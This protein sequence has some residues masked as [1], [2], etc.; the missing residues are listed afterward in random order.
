MRQI[1]LLYDHIETEAA[2][3]ADAI[4]GLPQEVTALG[5][6]RK[7]GREVEWQT[8]LAEWKNENKQYKDVKSLADLLAEVCSRKDVLGFDSD[9]KDLLIEG[10]SC[11][12]VEGKI[13]EAYDKLLVMK[14]V[15]QDNLGNSKSFTP[16]QAARY[17]EEQGYFLPSS[18]LTS[19]I[20]V[21]L[22]QNLEIP[23]AKEVLDQYE[24]RNILQAQN[25]II[26]YNAPKIIH[27]PQH[28]DFSSYGGT[29][30][31][32]RKVELPFEKIRKNGLFSRDDVLRNKTLEEGLQDPLVA[33]FVRKFTGL[34]DPS[35]LI[36]IGQSFQRTVT[37]WFPDKAEDCTE[38]KAVW[39]GCD[40]LSFYLIGDNYLN[41]SSAARGVRRIGGRKRNRKM[42]NQN[43]R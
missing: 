20:L 22:F 3:E 21:T 5:V 4:V 31:S 34:A 27:Y 9:E 36:Q 41:I 33:P 26:N 8:A 23:G 14:D 13:T 29:N 6:A 24:N 25:T 2:F 1:T 7:Y 11:V 42:R 19:A 15:F 38:T 40:D 39:L 12:D 30:A 28:T 17:A 18:Q 16:Y 32:R 10:I 43:L 37:V 35:I